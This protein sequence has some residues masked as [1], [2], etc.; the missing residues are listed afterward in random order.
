MY[1]SV[2][3]GTLWTFWEYISLIFSIIC[4]IQQENKYTY[5]TVLYI[6]S[7]NLYLK[8]LLSLEEMS[9]IFSFSLKKEY[10]FWIQYKKWFKICYCIFDLENIADQCYQLLI[11]HKT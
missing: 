5:N 2:Y 8:N 7:K 11:L 1:F 3:Y 4:L 10:D 9:M 6:S